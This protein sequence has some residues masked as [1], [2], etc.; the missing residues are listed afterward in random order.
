MMNPEPERL[1]PPRPVVAC[2]CCCLSKNSSKKSWNGEPSGRSRRRNVARARDRLAGRDI[3][4]R[5]EQFGGDVGDRFRPAR[6][7]PATETPSDDP[8]AQRP[9]HRRIVWS[10]PTSPPRDARTVIGLSPEIATDAVAPKR[11]TQHPSIMIELGRNGDPDR[12][13][14]HRL[15]R[16]C[17]RRRLPSRRRVGRPER[18]RIR[19]VGWRASAYGRRRGR[20]SPC[21]APPRP[22]VPAPPRSAPASAAARARPGGLTGAGVIVRPVASLKNRKNSESGEITSRVSDCA[23]RPC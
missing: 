19:G 15:T 7:M 2:S 13:R 5:V 22:S 10:S 4:H 12:G 8:E 3:D 9:A 16:S 6:R 23:P 21:R 18:R 14:R 20:P 1:H 11:T 17:C